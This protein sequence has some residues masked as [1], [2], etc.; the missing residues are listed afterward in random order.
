MSGNSKLS[1]LDAKINEIKQLLFPDY[2]VTPYHDLT[3][4]IILQQH[5]YYVSKEE[6]EEEVQ[7]PDEFEEEKEEVQEDSGSQIELSEEAVE[8]EE[9]T[10]ASE[11]KDQDGEQVNVDEPP[12]KNPEEE[13]L[14]KQTYH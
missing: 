2:M 11:Q 4:D 10:E 8:E 12:K 5:K 6:H 13:E 7:E 14:I 3:A 1:E 9:K